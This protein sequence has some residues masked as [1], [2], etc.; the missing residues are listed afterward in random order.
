MKAALFLCVFMVAVLAVVPAS[1]QLIVYD[2][3]QEKVLDPNK[4]LGRGASDTGVD[5]LEFGRQIKNDPLFG[6][7]WLEIFN[8][9]Y[10]SV[11]SDTGRSTAYNRLLFL[12]GSNIATIQATVLIRKIQATGCSTNTLSTQPQAR[13]GGMYFNTGTAIPGDATNDVRAFIIIT[14]P[15]DSTNSSNVL[16]ITGTVVLCNDADCATNTPIGTKEVG[17]AIVNLPVKVRITW[18]AVGN[19]FVFQKGK[20]PEVEILNTQT[21]GGAPGAG[22]GGN[23]RVEVNHQIPNCTDPVRPM[24]FMDAYF[25]NIKINP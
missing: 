9:S 22:N 12:D 21:V 17:K 11:A 1:A 20:A 5:T 13:I 19:R 4:W 16:D 23:K 18:D 15:S 8:R 3:F 10:A 25:D 2:D 24:S 6:L 14:R 7:R